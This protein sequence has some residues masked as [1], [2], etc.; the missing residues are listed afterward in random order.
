MIIRREI[1]DFDSLKD[2]LWSG[3]IQTME[4]I[5]ENDKEDEF[6]DL[7]DELFPEGED[8]TNLN[9]FIRFDS[10]YIFETLGISEEDVED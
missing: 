4:T 8:L 5:E 2:E 1:N 10:D 9:D 3:A 7:L 6:M